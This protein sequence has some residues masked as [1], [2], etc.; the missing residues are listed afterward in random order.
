MLTEGSAAPDADI[1][2]PPRTGSSGGLLFE[3]PFP[4]LGRRCEQAALPLGLPPAF[5]RWH[6]RGMMMKATFFPLI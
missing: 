5:K 1:D 6:S 4:S 3:G 2:L